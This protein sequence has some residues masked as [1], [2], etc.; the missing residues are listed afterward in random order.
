MSE[1]D[2]P[3]TVELLAR[4][5]EG[6]Q[7]AEEELFSRYTTQLVALARSRL[8]PKLAGRVDAEDVV[9]SAYRSFF[10]AADRFV[11]QRR[12][13]TSGGFWPRSPCA[14][15]TA[16]P[17]GTRPCGAMSRVRPRWA[18]RLVSPAFRSKSWLAIHR[19]TRPSR[20]STSSSR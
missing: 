3:S 11:I 14:S 10:L 1:R 17:A 2:E 12:S 19:P 9:Q 16:R 7:Q 8:S 15:F 20:S 13:A 6:D 18:R 4:W 5:R